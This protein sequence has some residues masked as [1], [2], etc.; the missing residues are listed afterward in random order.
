MVCEF[1]IYVYHVCFLVIKA[2]MRGGNLE[3]VLRILLT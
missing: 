1:V 3:R 2:Y